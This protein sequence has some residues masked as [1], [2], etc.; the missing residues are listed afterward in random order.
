MMS[1]VGMRIVIVQGFEVFLKLEGGIE[2]SFVR[3]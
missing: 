3:K 1:F 2:L